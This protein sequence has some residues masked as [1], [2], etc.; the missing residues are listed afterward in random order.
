L[1]RGGILYQGYFLRA[2]TIV[3]LVWAWTRLEDA[4]AASAG[5]DAFSRWIRPELGMRTKMVLQAIE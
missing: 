4:G 2:T 3:M 1:G 5:M